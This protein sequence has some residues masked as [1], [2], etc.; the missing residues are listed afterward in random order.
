MFPEEYL[1]ILA[2]RQCKNIGNTNLRKLIQIKG[3][4]KAVWETPKKNLLSIS[5]IGTKITQDIGKKEFLLKAEKELKF[6]DQKSI[7]IVSHN[8]S[9]Y[10]K[11]LSNCDDAPAILFY[12]G[13]LIYNLNPLSIVGT[14]KLTSY[15]KQFIHELLT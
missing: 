10:P 7:S 11:H 9:S 2:L 6:C 5:G 13:K 4:A 1:Y 3:S 12:R 8:D 15:G 14:R